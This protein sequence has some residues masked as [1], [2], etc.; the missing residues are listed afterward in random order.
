MTGSEATVIRGESQIMKTAQYLV[1]SLVG[2]SLLCLT[3]CFSYKKTESVEPLPST[4]VVQPVTSGRDQR[5]LIN[6]YD[7][8]NWLQRR[9]K[10]T[11]YHEPWLLIVHTQ[12][13]RASIWLD[14]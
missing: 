14:T 6:H 9:R 8:N 11:Q 5:I 7:H 12:P 4:T 2:G 10:A 1:A 3:G 13:T